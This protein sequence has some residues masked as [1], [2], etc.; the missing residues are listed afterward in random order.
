MEDEKL[1]DR[2]VKQYLISE[3]YTSTLNAFESEQSKREKSKRRVCALMFSA[4][5]LLPR[6]I[7][8]PCVRCGAYQG[9]I[10]EYV[11]GAADTDLGSVANH[12]LLPTR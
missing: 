6:S 3:N 12:I 10:D 11:L 4:D 7:V 2:I 1:S 5:V 8:Q 9:C